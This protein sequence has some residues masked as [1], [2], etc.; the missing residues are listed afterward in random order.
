M[1]ARDRFFLVVFLIIQI[2]LTGLDVMGVLLI[3][4][5]ATVAT[6]AVQETQPNS[7]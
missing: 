5:I 2:S 1:N 6:S 3:A 7:I 4:V